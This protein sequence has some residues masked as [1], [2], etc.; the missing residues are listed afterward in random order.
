MGDG[1]RIPGAGEKSERGSGGA[2]AADEFEC[3]L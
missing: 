1:G 3:Q 2:A